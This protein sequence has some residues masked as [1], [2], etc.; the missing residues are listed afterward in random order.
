MDK[1]QQ[2]DYLFLVHHLRKWMVWPRE[3]GIEAVIQVKQAYHI[4]YGQEALREV[5]AQ[6][7]NEMISENLGRLN[8]VS[9]ADC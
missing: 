7:G 5:V 2:E 3:I 4:K 6:V 1:Q 8:D 9:Y